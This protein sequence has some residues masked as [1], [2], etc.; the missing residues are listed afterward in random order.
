[1]KKTLLFLAFVALFAVKSFSQETE[2]V[3]FSQDGERFWLVIDGVL[4]NQEPQP[5][6]QVGGLTKEAY[7]VK[8]IFEIETIPD[9]NQSISTTDVDGTKV[10]ATY[11]I[12]KWRKKYRL[13]ASSWEEVPSASP[14]TQTI[15][16]QT[17]G[18]SGKPQKPVTQQ[19]VAQQPVVHTDQTTVTTS[20]G[21]TVKLPDGTVITFAPG[22]VIDTQYLDYIVVEE[23][24]DFHP[25][26]PVATRPIRY[27]APTPEPIYYVPG[28]TGA[29]GCSMPMD[30][31]AFDRAKNTIK[32]NSFESD[33]LSTSKQ[34]A[35]NNCLTVNQV[36]EI[37]ELFSFESTKLEFAKFAYR[38]TYDIGNYYEVNNAF[39]YSSSKQELNNYINRNK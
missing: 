1:M 22:A 39:T 27:P 17:Q 13:W 3:I 30:N 33:M 32:N 28:Y 7:R 31:N 10:N 16:L 21:V 12:T 34:V 38:Y 37:I 2:V 23:T 20:T 6:V 14:G 18:P 29:I 4:Q 9:I 19:P 25:E 11:R 24:V 36:V 5:R 8:I 15:H 26:R 35:S